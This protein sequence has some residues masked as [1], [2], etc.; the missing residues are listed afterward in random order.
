MAIVP[1]AGSGVAEFP[2]TGAAGKRGGP[3]RRRTSD[4]VAVRAGRAAT[5]SEAATPSGAILGYQVRH[6]ARRY[7]LFIQGR[8]REFGPRGLSAAGI[9]RCSAPVRKRSA[10][11]DAG[12]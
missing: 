6:G 5:P 11:A 2:T 8:S 10:F 4:T 1:R 9:A 12:A 3:G 7:D